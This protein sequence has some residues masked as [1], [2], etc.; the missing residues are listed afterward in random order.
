MT[1]GIFHHL[2][3]VHRFEQ[4]NQ[5]TVMIDEFDFAS[6]VGL[7]GALIDAI[8]LKRYLKKLLIERNQLIKKYAECDEW[9]NFIP[10]QAT[11]N[12]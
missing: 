7:L 8:F 11:G 4:R 3:H 2:H 10:L 6:P 12:L 5:A 1:K 9:K